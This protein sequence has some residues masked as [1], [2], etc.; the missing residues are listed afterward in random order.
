MREDDL[1]PAEK[2][3][4]EVQYSDQS[5]EYLRDYCAEHAFDLT[6][7]FDGDVQSANAFDFHSTVWYTTNTVLVKN[8]QQSVDITDIVPTGFALFGE[9]A[10]IL[11]LEITSVSLSDIRESLG[12]EY[13][14]QDQWPDYKPHITLCY[15]FAGDLPTVA[16]PDGDQLT[17]TKLNI[18]SQK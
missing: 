1:T 3:Y 8:S 17:G 4:I 10:N 15:S 7:K 18:K 12:D 5:Q 9:D 16:L 2:K 13:Q 6:V 11:V 14:L